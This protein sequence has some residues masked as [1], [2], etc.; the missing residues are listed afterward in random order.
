VLLSGLGAVDLKVCDSVWTAPLCC[1]DWYRN[2]SPSKCPDYIAALKA[3]FPE[4]PAPPAVGVPP[5]TE[6]GT[7][8]DPNA[9]NA[10][11]AEQAAAWKAQMQAFMDKLASEQPEKKCSWYQSLASDGATC[12]IGGTALWMLAAGGGALLVVLAQRRRR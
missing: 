7:V 12:K 9:S 3:E 5:M 1:Y 2:M 6:H 10:I 11:I 8:T 4:I